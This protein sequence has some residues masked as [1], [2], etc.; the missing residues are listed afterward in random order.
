MKYFI[1]V[2]PISFFLEQNDYFG[3]NAIPQSDAELMVDGLT[4]IMILLALIFIRTR[5]NETQ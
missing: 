4:S 2:I 1:G 3:W 5:T